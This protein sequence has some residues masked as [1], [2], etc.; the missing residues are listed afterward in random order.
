MKLHIQ[1][2]SI[3]LSAQLLIY[4]GH[5][6]A[7]EAPSGFSF[8]RHIGFITYENKKTILAI[9]NSDLK[10]GQKLFVMHE[11]IGDT[12]GIQEATIIRRLKHG[13]KYLRAMT[14]FKR[15]PVLY[16]ID[17][18]GKEAVAFIPV[19][20]LSKYDPKQLA[21]DIDGDGNFEYL[22]TCASREGVH[23]LVRSGHPRA[24][25][26]RKDFYYYLGYDVERTCQDSDY[27]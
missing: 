2:L 6:Y 10:K 26:L 1:L 25:I 12:H 19:S 5:V 11:S 15:K 27:M 4:C 20:G 22:Y 23:Y 13:K 8:D 16:E 3:M 17:K 24:G 7:E 9:E 21:I 14:A 18:P